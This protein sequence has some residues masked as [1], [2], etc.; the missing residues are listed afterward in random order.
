MAVY[1][2]EGMERCGKTTT[3]NYLRS[4]LKNPKL[5]VHHAAK[6]PKGVNAYEWSRSHYFNLSVTF[7]DMSKDGWDI[8]MDRSHIGE[9]V[10]GHLYRGVDADDLSTS[11]LFDRFFNVCTTSLIM[12]VDHAENVIA[13]DDGLSLAQNLGNVQ[14]ERDRFVDAFKKSTLV[15]KHLIDWNSPDFWHMSTQEKFAKAFKHIDTMVEK[16]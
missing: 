14:Q 5:I 13:R 15:K 7:N 2:V 9:Y 10:Y 11:L 12:L 16:K 4:I 6:P 8:I 1:I 3:V